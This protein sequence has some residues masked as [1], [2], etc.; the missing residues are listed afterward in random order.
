VDED[1]AWCGACYGEVG[2]SPTRFPQEVK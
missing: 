1:G 2:H